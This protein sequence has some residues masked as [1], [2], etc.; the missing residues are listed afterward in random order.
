MIRIPAL[1]PD[2]I[3]DV[4]A[5]QRVVFSSAAE[6]REFEGDLYCAVVGEIDGRRTAREIVTVL[7]R[8][9]RPEEIYYVLAILAREG[10]TVES[11]AA[12]S[13]DAAWWYSAGVPV[14]QAR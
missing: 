6:S 9:Y 10:L 4:I 12:A 1:R 5:H 11:S 8:L 3:L 7:E 14:E 2:L 13:R